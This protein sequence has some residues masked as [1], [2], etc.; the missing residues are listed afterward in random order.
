MLFGKASALATVHMLATTEVAKEKIAVG[1]EMEKRHEKETI[2]TKL[3]CSLGQEIQSKSV[4]QM[5][6]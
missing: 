6:I 2:E 3:T 1:G 5:S 4:G